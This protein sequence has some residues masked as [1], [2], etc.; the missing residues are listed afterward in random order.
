[1]Q[2]QKQFR[3][4]GS[5]ALVVL[6]ALY[7]AALY[8]RPAAA[9]GSSVSGRIAYTGAL[10]PVGPGRPLCLCFY[11]RPDLT[12]GLGCA[13]YRSNPVNYRVSLQAGTYYVVAFLD[14]EIDEILDPG[15]PYQIYQNRGA[16]PADPVL[17]SPGTTEIDFIFGD[18]NLSGATTETP[19][20][21]PA[22]TP[23]ATSPPTATVTPSA[24]MPPTATATLAA[25]PAPLDCPGD[26][27]HDEM[28][29]IDEIVLAVGIAL[30][31]QGPGDCPA[32]DLDLDGEIRIAEIVTAVNQAL[33]GCTAAENP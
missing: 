29:T 24:T 15:E 2:A 26:C 14:I 31:L 4:R 19:T 21:E 8:P 11:R 27:N 12:L 13:I 32:A 17:A 23:T 6:L 3:T 20:P 22:A 25:T 16:V 10:G 9:Q 7:A 18:E 33:Y 5:T 30:G 28:V 1:M